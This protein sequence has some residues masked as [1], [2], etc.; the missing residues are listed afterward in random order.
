MDIGSSSQR[1]RYSMFF[2]KDKMIYHKMKGNRT[3]DLQ[4]DLDNLLGFL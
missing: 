4:K 3:N 1:R 2:L